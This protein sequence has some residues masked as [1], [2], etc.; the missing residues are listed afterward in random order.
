M[1]GVDA[2]FLA[3]LLA[4]VFALILLFFHLYSVPKNFPEHCGKCKGGEMSYVGS[5]ILCTKHRCNNCGHV[6]RVWKGLSNI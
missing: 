6:D 5:S 4:F 1:I 2:M 3:F